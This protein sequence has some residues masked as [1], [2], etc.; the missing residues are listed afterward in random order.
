MRK[1][2]GAARHPNGAKRD[3]EVLPGHMPGIL[4]VG[5][6]VRLCTIRPNHL[7]FLDSFLDSFLG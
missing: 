6:M 7:C 2:R 5:W 4:G 1:I 3:Q